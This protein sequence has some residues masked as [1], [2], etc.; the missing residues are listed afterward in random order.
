MGSAG[1]WVAVT[2]C[3]G[4]R[5]QAF[6][7][8]RSS[9]AHRKSTGTTGVLMDDRVLHDRVSLCSVWVTGCM[10]YGSSLSG[11]WLLGSPEILG[12]SFVGVLHRRS[13]SISLNSPD[14]TLNLSVS[15]SETLSDF[16]SPTR[17]LPLNLSISHGLVCR[18]SKEK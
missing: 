2:G 5:V 14:P 13:G 16:S 17:H 7:F 6:G 11:L 12:F 3:T 15:P 1:H 4:S 8:H 18:R 9:L 10:G